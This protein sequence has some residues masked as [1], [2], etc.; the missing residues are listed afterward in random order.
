MK[1]HFSR[2]EKINSLFI[3]SNMSFGSLMVGY[4]FSCY[5]QCIANGRDMQQSTDVVAGCAFS[6]EAVARM[7]PLQF[8]SDRDCFGKLWILLRGV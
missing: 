3:Q 7:V 2:D 5:P 8:T 4:R 6:C 1:K